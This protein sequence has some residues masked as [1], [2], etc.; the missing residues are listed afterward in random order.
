PG[1]TSR[2]MAIH[3]R[4]LE[5]YQQI[6]IADEVVAKGIIIEHLNLRKNGNRIISVDL[7]N[8][9]KNESPFPFV[10]SFPQDEHEKLL[11]D[12]LEKRGFFVE[13]NTELIS[14][15]QDENQVVATVKKDNQIQTLSTP[16]IFGC[17]GARST[18]RSQ[19]GI[20]F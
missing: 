1:Q 15:T 12:H 2:A 6:G 10:L 3:A 4:I 13:R 11:I 9:G 8:L 19:L 14:F 18:V 16:F 20:E 7:C 5:F 17:D